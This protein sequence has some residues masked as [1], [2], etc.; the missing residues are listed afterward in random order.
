KLLE[1]ILSYT[2]TAPEIYLGKIVSSLT[3]MRASFES[4]EI[5]KDNCIITGSIPLATSM[6]YS[7]KLLALTGGKGKFSSRF[8]NYAE[9]PEGEG[10][11][12][13]YR[14]VSPLDRSKFILKARK[15]L[16]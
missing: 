1:P 15:A 13:P 11:S 12:T 6:D 10:K 8:S 3:Q 2:I 4:P 14:G 7:I 9:C 5:I 16:Q